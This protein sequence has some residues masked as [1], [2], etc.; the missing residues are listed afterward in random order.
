MAFPT[1]P[2]RGDTHTEEDTVYTFNGISWDRTII[3]SNNDTS[4][5]SIGSILP[6]GG[7]AGQV[8]SRPSGGGLEWADGGGTDVSTLIARLEALEAILLNTDYLTL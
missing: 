7:T 1:D 3:G 8:L 6:S 5:S 2:Q 4:Y